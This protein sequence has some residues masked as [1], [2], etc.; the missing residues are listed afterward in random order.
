MKRI[1]PILLLVLASALSASIEGYS[2]GDSYLMRAEGV[3]CIMTNPALLAN[4]HDYNRDITFFDIALGVRNNAVSN[5]RLNDWSG[6]YLTQKDKDDLLDSIQESMQINLNMDMTLFAASYRSSGFHVGLHAA[7]G[8]KVSKK[9]LD[10][11]LNGNNYGKTYHFTKDENDARAMAY[12][13]VSYASEASTLDRYFTVLQSYRIPRIQVGYSVSLL[14]PIAGEYL[15][16]YNG[17]FSTSDESGLQVD[18][19]IRMR[20]GFG[21]YGFKGMLAFA[22][23]IDDHWSAGITFDNLLGFLKIQGNPEEHFYTLKS[24]SIYVSNLDEDLFRDSTYTRDSDEFQLTLPVVIRMGGLYRQDKWSVS[25]D[26]VQYCSSDALT[27]TMP[28]LNLCGELMATPIMPVRLAFSTGDE[29]DPLA[30]TWGAGLRF[31][32]TW[33][34]IGY[35]VDGSIL[36]FFGAKGGGFSLSSR[37]MF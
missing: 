31:K 23:Q 14:V 12:A 29:N 21:G 32:H 1:L 27:S 35:R 13:D 30:F 37:Y 33:F 6:K 19:K 7:G 5:S 22:S 8:A 15:P 34:D 36:P 9:Y 20:T 26:Y 4:P 2:Y 25:A 18:Q 11:I 10:L 3:N 24:D 16:S 17:T 28:H